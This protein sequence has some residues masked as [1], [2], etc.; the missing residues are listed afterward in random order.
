[1]RQQIQELEAEYKMA[2]EVIKDAEDAVASNLNPT[3]PLESDLN[4]IESAV[5]REYKQ[6]FALWAAV[7]AS[8][9]HML[10]RAMERERKERQ[11]EMEE[12]LRMR[13]LGDEEE[14]DEGLSKL[15]LTASLLPPAEEVGGLEAGLAS[16]LRPK[17]ANLA[18]RKEA[19]SSSTNLSPQ[20]LSEFFNH[21]ALINPSKIS[22]SKEELAKCMYE[23]KWCDLICENLADQV[24]TSC[25]EHGRLLRDLRTRYAKSFMTASRLHSDALW[26]LDSVVAGLIR[27]WR[28]L[29]DAESLWQQHEVK[30][31]EEADGRIL[32]IEKN[33]E[34]EY[35]ETL[36]VRTHAT[37]E[38]ERISNTLKTLK[39]I[40]NDM[41]NDKINMTINDLNS[42]V[43]AQSKEIKALKE[44]N[45]QIK[46]AKDELLRERIKTALAKKEIDKL[47][48]QVEE[49]AEQLS[50]KDA[51][52]EALTEEEYQRRVEVEKLKAKL[53]ANDDTSDE[54]D[55]NGGP[56][57]P[58]V[59]GAQSTMY[60][61]RITEKG[62]VIWKQPMGEVDNVA[63]ELMRAKP[64]HRLLCHNYRLMLPNIGPGNRPP[65]NLFWVRRCMRA[66]IHAKTM[67]DASLSNRE[68]SRTRFPEL[69]Y[70]WFEPDSVYIKGIEV[71]VSEE[72]SDEALRISRRLALL[73]ANTVLTS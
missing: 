48:A 63:D 45:S 51:E 57:N 47:K 11:G 50:K 25:M 31:L 44:K 27:C 17:S 42:N 15:G 10:K 46:E 7:E 71:R 12:G 72:R 19:Y 14:E 33:A 34:Q 53:E 36:K 8:R 59:S 20:R 28:R 21:I 22:N 62:E 24:G 6:R 38:V 9:E 60:M 52:I 67:D 61:A 2:M 39:G 37:K 5:D 1:M 55:G 58:G 30:L 16:S 26:Q 3:N 73:V 32:N 29:E 43:V 18:F 56:G 23:Q 65:R 69:V 49:Q 68:E 41:Q 66:I 4:G 13:G 70:S 35:L 40:F 64:N 54:E